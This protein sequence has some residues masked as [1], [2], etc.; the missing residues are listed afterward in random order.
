MRKGVWFSANMKAIS[1]KIGFITKVAN[2]GKPYWLLR[3]FLNYK[4]KVFTNCPVCF[5]I[6]S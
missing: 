6:L 5:Y 2:T 4:M 1:T 3:V